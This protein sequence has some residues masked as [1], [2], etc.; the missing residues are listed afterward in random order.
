MKDEDSRLSVCAT[1]TLELGID[2]GRLERAFQIDAPYTVS[3]FLQRMGRTGRRGDPAEMWFV[4]REE[5]WEA[6]AMLPDSI[7]WYL[8]QGIALVQ[9]YIEERFVEPAVAALGGRSRARVILIDR[10]YLHVGE[11]D[12]SFAVLAGQDLVDGDRSRPRG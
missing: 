5:H 1:A 2:I 11:G 4:M 3:G 7:P 8:I 6:R 10:E 9:L 12:L